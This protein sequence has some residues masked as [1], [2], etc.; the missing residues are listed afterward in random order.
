[1]VAERQSCRDAVGQF[2]WVGDLVGGVRL[3]QHPVTVAGQVVRIGERQVRVRVMLV[4][5]TGDHDRRSTQYVNRPEVG[6]EVLVY[7]ERVFKVDAIFVE[8]ETETDDCE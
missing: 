8:E 3:G 1:M 7:H 5:D 4:T 6:D 2:V